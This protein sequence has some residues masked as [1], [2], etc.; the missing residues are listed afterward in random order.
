MDD[1]VEL[2]RAL[3]ARDEAGVERSRAARLRRFLCGTD[4]SRL[5]ASPRAALPP[6]LLL[7]ALTSAGAVAAG[8]SGGIAAW[9]PAIRAGLAAAA[10]APDTVAAAVL[11]AALSDRD[12]AIAILG[13]AVAGPALLLVL[14]EL[15]AD[16]RR[17]FGR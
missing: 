5:R 3:V 12:T 8:A 7:A 11:G 1:N 2:M 4:R 6:L 15:L 14:V 9:V 17:T 13:A 10:A 16:L